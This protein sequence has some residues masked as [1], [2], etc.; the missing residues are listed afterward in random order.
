MHLTYDRVD[1][2]GEEKRWPCGQVLLEI[3]VA[4]RGL[5]TISLA[6]R[7]SDQAREALLE[8]HGALDTAPGAEPPDGPVSRISVATGLMPNQIQDVIGTTTH[9]GEIQVGGDL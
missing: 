3:T 8:L 2:L 7:L 6:G 4:L 5:A 9:V 1:G